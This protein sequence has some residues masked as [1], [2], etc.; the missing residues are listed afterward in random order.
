MEVAVVKQHQLHN[1]VN[2]TH[3]ISNDSKLT[4][5]ALFFLIIFNSL[6]KNAP[7]SGNCTVATY[8][9]RSALSTFLI[10]LSFIVGVFNNLNWWQLYRKLACDVIRN[11]KCALQTGGSTEL[12]SAF[13]T[14]S[15]IEHWNRN[16]FYLTIC[17]H[18]KENQWWKWQSSLN[19][20]PVLLFIFW[21]VFNASD[22]LSNL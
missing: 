6:K 11:T 12:K 4:Q 20:S 22:V 1:R 21:P 2:N 3:Y 7:K 17:I 9:Y 8:A 14:F 10:F 15:R 18:F 13:K 5:L 19:P 16:I